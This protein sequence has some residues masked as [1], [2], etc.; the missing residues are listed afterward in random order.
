MFELLLGHLVIFV[1]RCAIK[2][3]PEIA[4]PEGIIGLNDK[5]WFPVPVVGHHGFIVVQMLTI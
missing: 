2:K 1:T 4:S 3:Y 5:E